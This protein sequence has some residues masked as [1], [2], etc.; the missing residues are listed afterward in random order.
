[1]KSYKDH[2]DNQQGR[3]EKTDFGVDQDQQY[4]IKLQIEGKAD[5]Q[6]WISKSKAEIILW[7]WI[8][9]VK[10]GSMERR[11]DNWPLPSTFPLPSPPTFLLPTPSGLKDYNCGW[12]PKKIP[13]P[14][15]ALSSCWS[16][17]V[18]WLD[19]GVRRQARL[20]TIVLLLFVFVKVFGR[21]PYYADHTSMRLRNCKT[22]LK[23]SLFFLLSLL[24]QSYKE[25]QALCDRL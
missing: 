16:S 9:S 14:H 21:H 8:D 22:K 23:A 25:P 7:C 11:G 13:P 19:F 24:F 2:L 20:N 6:L 5:R 12:L 3:S 1:M 4:R 15:T 18:T 10:R 17:R